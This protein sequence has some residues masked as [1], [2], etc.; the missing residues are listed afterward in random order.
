MLHYRKAQSLMKLERRARVRDGSEGDGLFIA[1]KNDLAWMLLESVDL[2]AVRVEVH[3]N[4]GRWRESH[5]KTVSSSL[6]LPN[7]DEGR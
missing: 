6:C 3:F 4:M 7:L 2:G 1:A 5:P